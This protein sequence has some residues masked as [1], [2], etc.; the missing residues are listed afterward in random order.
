MEETPWDKYGN[1]KNPKCAN[2][3]AHCGFEASAV[4]DAMAHPLKA[5]WVSFKGPRTEGPMAEGPIPEYDLNAEPAKSRRT[6][7]IEV[8]D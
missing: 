6:I 1:S 4:E 7:P 8:A 2:C 3:M 5:A